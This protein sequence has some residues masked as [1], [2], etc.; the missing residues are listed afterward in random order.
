MA[1]IAPLLDRRVRFE[2]PVKASGFN[3]AGKGSWEL[4]AE[5]YANVQDMLP[6]RGERLDLRPNRRHER[7]GPY[8]P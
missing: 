1:N 4:V 6:S 3:R 2:R 8:L 5:V 7:H